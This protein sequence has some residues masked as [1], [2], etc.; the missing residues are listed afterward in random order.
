MPSR[1]GMCRLLGM[2]L[3]LTVAGRSVAFA[4]PSEPTQQG[5]TGVVVERTSGRAVPGA[6]V[7]VEGPGLSTTT[8]AGGRFL[9]E[10]VTSPQATLVVRAPGFLELRL[11]GV[12][13]GSPLTIELDPTPNY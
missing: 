7:T 3:A 6:V 8:N 1:I 9:I 4:Q 5:V 2:L 12:A 10:G 11:S 13:T